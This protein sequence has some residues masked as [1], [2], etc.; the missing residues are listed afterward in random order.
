MHIIDSTNPIN[1]NPFVI[2]KFIKNDESHYVVIE[3]FQTEYKIKVNKTDYH[4]G[5]KAFYL[6][7][8]VF[9]YPI[10]GK[11]KGDTFEDCEY[12]MEIEEIKQP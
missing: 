8:S 7:K 12:R 5:L 1:Y 2:K 6:K 9:C 11:M 10:G 4:K 3:P